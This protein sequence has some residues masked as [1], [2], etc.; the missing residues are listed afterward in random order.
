MVVNETLARRFWPDENPIGQRLKQGW[1]ESEGEQSPWREIVGV[2]SDVK[3]FG[4]GG[5][6]RRHR[7][8]R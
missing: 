5:R 1:P 3:Q 6:F 8:F 2:V 7:S 4:L